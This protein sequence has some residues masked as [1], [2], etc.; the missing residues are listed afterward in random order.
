MISKL[1]L[2]YIGFWPLAAALITALAVTASEFIP[3]A[4]RSRKMQLHT[5]LLGLLL[6]AGGYWPI[7]QR[8]SSGEQSCITYWNGIFVSDALSCIMGATACIMGLITLAAS[9]KSIMK[10]ADRSDNFITLTVFAACG[11]AAA[12]ATKDM[13]VF[14]LASELISLPLCFMAF[15]STDRSGKTKSGLNC[16]AMHAAASAFFLY[17]M[18]LVFATAGSTSIDGAMRT[19]AGFNSSCAPRQLLI[20]GSV[21]IYA[22]LCIK[23]AAAPFHTWAADI[24]ANTVSPVGLFVSS[25]PKAAVTAFMLRLFW[26]C[27]A[28]Q[29]LDLGFEE[30]WAVIFAVSAALSII[31]GSAAAAAQT[32][33]KR[34]L[35][36]LGIA[37]IGTALFGVMAASSGGAASRG[38]ASAIFF[39][40]FYSLANAAA[41]GVISACGD[42]LNGSSISALQ[43]LHKRSP[44]LAAVMLAAMLSLAGVPP[45]AG[46]MSQFFVFSSVWDAQ[47]AWWW[48]VALG[49]AGAVLSLA[50]CSKVIK[51]IFSSPDPQNSSVIEVPVMTRWSLLFCLAAITI[52]S[53][54]PGVMAAAV[55][56]GHSIYQ[57]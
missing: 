56:A 38:A 18:A 14:A 19:F 41:W 12:S 27:L 43:G 21:F 42:D 45:L 7:W 34:M 24:C 30:I 36:Y 48:A 2:T 44:L 51:T 32:D 16:F 46:F 31:W 52:L 13:A 26:G 39:I 1:C 5:A 11:V 57:F 15:S 33:V 54:S 6:S 17:G 49:M 28:V 35:S 9:E 8:I 29:G 3:G 10:H 53:V 4:E 47:S 20:L 22:G 40:C 37:Q 50:G 23:L 55:K 25:V